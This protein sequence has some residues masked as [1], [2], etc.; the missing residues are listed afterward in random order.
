[1]VSGSGQEQYLWVPEYWA[2]FIRELIHPEDLLS[3]VVCEVLWG[4]LH[5]F[6][7]MT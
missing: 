3:V 4:V 6:C 7:M 2:H 1:M 5:L